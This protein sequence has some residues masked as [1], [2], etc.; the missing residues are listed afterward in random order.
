MIP[1]GGAFVKIR[2]LDLA[3]QA[4]NTKRDFRKAISQEMLTY[5]SERVQCLIIK[6]L[7]LGLS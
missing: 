5:N 4:F 1:P 7:H 6:S 2:Q 3:D